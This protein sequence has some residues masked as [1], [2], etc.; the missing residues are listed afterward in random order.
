MPCYK[1]LEAFHAPGGVSFDKSKSFGIPVQLPCGRCIGC[2]LEKAKQ[3]ALRCHHE[4]SMH[5]H[6]DFLTLTYA[7]ENL[8][9][10]NSLRKR[11][12]QKFIRALRKKTGAKIR[13]YM[14]GEYGNICPDHGGWINDP[15][16]NKTQ[17]AVCRTGRPHYHA[18]IFGFKFPNQKLVNI[19]NGNRV[20]TSDLVSKLWTYGSHEL[21]CV[22]F[23]SAGYVARYILKK[24]N[25]EYAL[26]EYAILDPETG[27]LTDEK[28]IPPYTCMS[29]GHTCRVCKKRSCKRSTGG[30][31]YSWYQRH[32]ADL[33]PHDFAVMPDGR[34]T[35]VPTYYRTLL[36]REDPAMANLL[37]AARVEKAKNDPNNSP[38]RLATRE[39]CKEKQ[40]ERLTRTL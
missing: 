20:Y 16:P 2:R 21:G 39:F 7:S 35:P 1:P 22:T 17:C 23:Q 26:R 24:Q 11:D 37:R 15:V 28:I 5:R 40:A 31:G 19:R 33:F 36:E 3:W 6:N 34:Q 4:S 13:Y 10:N 14:C 27:E 29:L 18:I 9:P 32:K 30:I 8:P 12:F 25:G 38:E